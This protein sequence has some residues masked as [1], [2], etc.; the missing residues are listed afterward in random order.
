MITKST[1]FQQE[2]LNIAATVTAIA[3]YDLKDIKAN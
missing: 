2:S 3:K 1:K